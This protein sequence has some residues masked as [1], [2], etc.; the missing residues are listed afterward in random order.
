[1]QNRLF[2]WFKMNLGFSRKE[3]RGFVLVFPLLL[4]L[5]IS[6]DLIRKVKNRRA[7]RLF[8][9]YTKSLDSLEKIGFTLVASPLP[10]FNPADTLKKFSNSKVSDRISRLPLSESDSITL[11]IVPGIGASTAGRIIK[12]REKLG[13]FHSQDQ[14]KEIFGLNPE[15]IERIWEYF[16]FDAKVYRKIKLNQV[17]LEELS[18]HPY[19]SY[20]EAK[21]LLAYRKQH[22]N[23][24]SKDDLMK[25][26]IFKKEW[27]DQLSPYLSFEH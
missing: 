25:I 15:V 6:P 18:K 17:D 1:M 21:V 11:Q 14:L 7:E 22:G 20:Q 26:K 16:E 19:L 4:M 12:Y 5:G 8:E 13:G 3:S 10:T 23:F 27:V 9:S 24:A 2:Y